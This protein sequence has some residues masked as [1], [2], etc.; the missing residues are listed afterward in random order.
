MVKPSRYGPPLEA[1]GVEGLALSFPPRRSSD[2]VQPVT[3][4]VTEYVPAITVVEFAMVGFCW[5]EV[6]P[7]G[8]VH[9]YVERLSADAICSNVG[10]SYSGLR[11]EAVGAAGRAL[12]TTDVDDGDEVQ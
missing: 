1:V 11:F 12:T 6:N 7:F 5:L 4:A 10:P 2:L 8:P 9:E 3:V